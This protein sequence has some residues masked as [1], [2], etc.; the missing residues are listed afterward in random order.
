[1]HAKT[2]F[3][4]KKEKKEGRMMMKKAVSILLVFY[5]CSCSGV[6]LPP[7]N[8][9]YEV[10]FKDYSVP[11]LQ[12][13]F[14]EVV[15]AYPISTSNQTFPF[16]SFA[17]GAGGGGLQTEIAH[18]VMMRGVA[19]H[20]FIMAALKSCS[21]GC[22]DGGWDTYYEEQLKV[23]V[24][25]QSP[26]MRQ[27]EVIGRVEHSLGYGICGH[28]MGGQATG[29]SATHASEYNIKAAILLH[30]YSGRMEDLAEDIQVPLLAVSGTDDDCCGE[31]S[32]RH[33]YDDA[34][35]P[36]SLAIAV[37]IGHQEP[38]LPNNIWRAYM[39]AF[40]KIYMLGDRGDYY[41]LIYD[42]NNPDSLCSYYDMSICEHQ[43]LLWKQN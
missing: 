5:C 35:V 40:F 26:E 13:P 31:D 43:N 20:G 14:A 32:A 4:N 24:W 25:A 2:L 17:H 8:G 16:I 33:Y 42:S 9:P 15:V 39:A 21:L 30:A 29:R 38:N 34:T 12:R 41:S 27:D 37:G 6:I 18:T 23:I 28:S 11:T 22:A 19:S 3:G 1:M 7:H 10:A 36:K